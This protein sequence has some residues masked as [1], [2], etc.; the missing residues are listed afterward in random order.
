MGRAFYHQEPLFAIVIVLVFN[1]LLR[2]TEML[3]HPRDNGLSIILPGSKTCQGNPQ[4]FLVTDSL[5]VRLVRRWLQP[6]SGEMLWPKGPH[7]F[8][9]AIVY[10]SG[11]PGL[12][13]VRLHPLLS[14]QGGERRGTF[15][16]PCHWMVQ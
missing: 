5:L 9:Q 3:V 4:V 2:A 7:L 13:S 8:R 11:V 14:P 16:Q 1:C 15:K 10:V 12:F 6:Q